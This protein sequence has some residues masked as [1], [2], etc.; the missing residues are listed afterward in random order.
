MC[1]KQRDNYPCRGACCSFVWTP[2]D[3]YQRGSCVADV[4]RCSAYTTFPLGYP[5]C[6]EF[7]QALLSIDVRARF[8]L[9]FDATSTSKEPSCHCRIVYCVDLLFP[10]VVCF[11]SV[12]PKTRKSTLLYPL[13]CYVCACA[14]PTGKNLDTLEYPAARQVLTPTPIL[15]RC[16]LLEFLLR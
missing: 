3:Y 1:G 10:F 5:I 2:P 6:D 9:L 14:E 7:V 8:F 12:P 15:P 13:L 4:D 16:V 11:R